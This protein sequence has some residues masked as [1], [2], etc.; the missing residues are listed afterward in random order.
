MSQTRRSQF[1]CA[2]PGIAITTQLSGQGR[3]KTQSAA[4]ERSWKEQPEAIEGC[5]Q[6]IIQASYFVGCEAVS[7]VAEKPRVL[8]SAQG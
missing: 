4:W 6:Q 7:E 2:A 3:S 8:V 1:P 5:E